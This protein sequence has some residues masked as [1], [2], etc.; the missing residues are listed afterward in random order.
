VEQ[1]AVAA[2]QPGADDAPTEMLTAVP[3]PEPPE[4]TELVTCPECGRTATV[5]LNR[6]EARDFCLGCDYPLFW[7]PSAVLRD[8]STA[9]ADDSLRR[10]PGTVGRATVA[11]QPCPHCNEPNRLT[12]VTCVRCGLPMQLAAPAPQPEPVYLPP[13][14]P[15]EPEPEPERGVPWW[16]WALL[17]FGTAATLVLIVLA[18]LGTFS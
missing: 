14:P 8:P 18:S 3:A 2:Q 4:A 13:P 6:R 16:V 7:T 9:T 5:T 15:P 11:S 12:A 1:P 10:L 17:A